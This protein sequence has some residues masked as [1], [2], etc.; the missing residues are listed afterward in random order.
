[1]ADPE[2]VHGEGGRGGGGDK[3]TEKQ[4]MLNF[5]IFDSRKILGRFEGKLAEI[6]LIFSGPRPRVYLLYEFN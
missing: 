6:S 2:S 3:Y 4:V 1:M 5:S